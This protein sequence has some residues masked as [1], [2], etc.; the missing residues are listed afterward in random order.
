VTGQTTL[1]VTFARFGNTLRRRVRVWLGSR[2]GQRCERVGSLFS[3]FPV[4]APNRPISPNAK[5]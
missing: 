3:P 2:H 1:W 4:W 5:P